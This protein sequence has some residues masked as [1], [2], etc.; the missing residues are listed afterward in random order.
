[1]PSHLLAL[2]LVVPAANVAEERAETEVGRTVWSVPTPEQDQTTQRRTAA[3]PTPPPPVPPAQYSTSPLVQS[4]YDEVLPALAA[5]NAMVSK[6]TTAEQWSRRQQAVKPRLAGLFGPFPPQNRTKPPNV[7]HRGL[8]SNNTNTKPASNVDYTVQTMLV[9]TKPG[10]Y[11]PAALWL[12]SMHASDGGDGIPAILYAVG[13]EGPG[14]RWNG[15][16]DWQNPGGDQ[17]VQLNLVKRG[18]AVLAFDP[19]GQGE[20]QMYPELTGGLAS[21]KAGQNPPLATENLLENTDGYP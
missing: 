6:L 1:M 7:V 19:I 13:H 16:D 10:Y 20:R 3:W 15:S 11:V 4:L 2:L 21:Y 14:M 9:E 5:R 18:F 8:R 12:P 17:I